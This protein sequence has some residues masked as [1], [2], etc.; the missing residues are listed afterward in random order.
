MASRSSMR[1]RLVE[2]DGAVMLNWSMAA[3]AV[4]RQA[5]AQNS[6]ARRTISG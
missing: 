1:F 4:G 3:R 6:S 2:E 5:G